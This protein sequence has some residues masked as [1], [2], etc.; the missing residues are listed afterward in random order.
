MQLPQVNL[1]AVIVATVINMVIGALWYS[2][3]L[4]ANRYVQYRGMTRD[5]MNQQMQNNM[6]MYAF[7]AIAWLITAFVLAMVVRAFGATTFVDGLIVGGL[8]WLGFVAT[9]TFVSTSFSGPN[10]KIWGLFA[11]YQLVSFLIMGVLLTLWR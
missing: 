2:P 4:F 9:T 11:G 6:S 3:P 10:Q 8:A 1:L 7:T 5:Q